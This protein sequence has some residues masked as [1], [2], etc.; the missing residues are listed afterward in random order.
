[1]IREQLEHDIEELLG[2]GLVAEFKLREGELK[3]RVA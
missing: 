2:S 1:M 3:A